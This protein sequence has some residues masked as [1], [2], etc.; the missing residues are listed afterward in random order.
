MP[1]KTTELGLSIESTT[2]AED[3]REDLPFVFQVGI[4]AS[5]KGRGLVKHHR[6]APQEPD[7]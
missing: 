2:E 1:A 6:L 3:E 4:L 7:V 5:V